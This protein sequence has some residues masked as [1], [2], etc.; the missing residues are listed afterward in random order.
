MEHYLESRSLEHHL[1][2]IISENIALTITDNCVSMIYVKRENGSICLRLHK[3]F[4]KAD[5][6]VINE[7]AGLIKNRKSAAVRVREFIKLNRS[8]I[9]QA[10]P[11]KITLHTDGRYH[12]L[13]KIFRWIN[14]KYFNNRITAKITW[15]RRSGRRYQKKTTQGVY[16]DD[17]NLIRINPLLDNPSVPD[18]YLAFVV[19]HEML[20][21]DTEVRVINGRRTV[22][23]RA[24]RQR[25]R[26]F[27]G[28]EKALEWEK[29]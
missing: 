15:G 20:H 9:R 3:M 2:Q 26:L 5:K 27:E 8:D 17:L 14:S 13:G 7:I 28:Y 4:L 21:A 12:D 10:K 11:R 1:R 22:H 18:Y 29:K 23:S 25:E 24:F 6:F 19:Y 16:R